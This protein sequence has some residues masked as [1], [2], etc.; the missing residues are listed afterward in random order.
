M[1]FL[2]ISVAGCFILTACAAIN[3]RMGW[4]DNNP[5]ELITEDV[6]ELS[7]GEHVD[8]SANKEEIK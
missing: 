8:L 6:I 7:S 4:K 5:V 2:L 3:K 1:K